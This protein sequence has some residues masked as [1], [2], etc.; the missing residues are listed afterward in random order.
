VLCKETNM[1]TCGEC[2]HW[3]RSCELRGK[4]LA[5]TP[6]W[7]S[8]RACDTD[9]YAGEDASCCDCFEPDG[10]LCNECGGTGKELVDII[11]KQLRVS[12]CAVCRGSGRKLVMASEGLVGSVV[13]NRCDG[14][15]TLLAGYTLDTSLWDLCDACE[16][17]G[18]T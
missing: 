14:K 16:G 3:M 10:S 11:D 5:N 18:R 17:K 12:P 9:V 15:G 6:K 2:A 7:V 13:C 8:Q 4:C 1:K